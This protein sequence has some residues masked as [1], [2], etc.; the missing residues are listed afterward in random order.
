M[1][2]SRTLVIDQLALNMRKPSAAPLVEPA[3]AV[4]IALSML[5]SKSTGHICSPESAAVRLILQS[6]KLAGWKFEPR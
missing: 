4:A 1:K 5:P 2:K 6:L 3:E